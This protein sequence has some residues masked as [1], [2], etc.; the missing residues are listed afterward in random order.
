MYRFYGWE[1]ADVRD[2]RGLDPR[3]YYDLLSDI[4]SAETCAPRMR[5]DWSPENHTLGQCSI[6]SF[7]MQ[8]LFGGKVYGV[9]LGDGNYHCL[10]DVRGCIFDLTSEQFGGKKLNYAN[11]PEQFREHHFAKAE[12]RQRYDQLSK[13]LFE[14]LS[15]M[16]ETERLT[17]RPFL[18]SDAADVWEYLKEPAVNC[19]ASMRLNSLGEAKAEMAKRAEDK[20]YYFAIV[21][22][23]SGKV[24][25][26]IF[27]HPEGTDPEDEVQDTFSPCWMLNLNYSGK[28]YAYEAARAYFDYLFRDK[29]ARRIYAYTEDNNLPSQHLCERLGMRREGL[30]MEFVSFV[31][32][33]D[34]TPLYENTLQYA[35][36][37][38]EW[39]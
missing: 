8:D 11:C 13:A 32:N 9:P 18:E 27:A 37:K 6:T 35:I 20:E 36:L 16:I 12:K 24:I 34:G 39:R 21:L 23:A 28:G 17:L 4:W 29:G 5:A 7:L 25:G 38:K 3:N 19:F 31:Q 1:T 10:H 26:E 14:R 2:K 15:G 22:K 33:P 30:F